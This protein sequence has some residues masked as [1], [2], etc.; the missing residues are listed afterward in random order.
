MNQRNVDFFAA[1]KDAKYVEVLFHNNSKRYGYLTVGDVRIGQ[2]LVVLTP[3][4]EL[5]V[6]SV[7][8]VESYIPADKVNI[9][10]KSIAGK[11]NIDGWWEAEHNAD[12][13]AKEREKSAFL[14]EVAKARGDVC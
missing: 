13:L 14:N 1:N 6:V 2:S 5:K 10:L 9:P 11:V 7:S 3:S 8:R 12:Q 4:Q